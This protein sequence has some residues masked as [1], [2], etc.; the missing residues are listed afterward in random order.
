VIVRAFLISSKKFSFLFSIAMLS[1]RLLQ[2]CAVL[3]TRTLRQTKF[4]RHSIHSLL[5][6]RSLGSPLPPKCVPPNPSLAA[7]CPIPRCISV[8][9]PSPFEFDLREMQKKKE[10]EKNESEKRER[11]DG[12]KK[13]RERREYLFFFLYQI[14][15]WG[16]GYSGSC[17]G[18]RFMLLF[19]DVAR[20]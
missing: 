7:P 6:S 18:G 4:F 2:R 14:C 11:D 16:V 20:N 5:P 9:L 10:R 3:S 1:A 17:W 13:K 19:W 8:H 15:S 12:E